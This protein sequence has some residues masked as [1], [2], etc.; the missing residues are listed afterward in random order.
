MSWGACSGWAYP[1]DWP[2]RLAGGRRSD[3]ARRFLTAPSARRPNA[4]CKDSISDVLVIVL[5][6]NFLSSRVLLRRNV[7]YG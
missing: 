7:G 5:I 4:V 1:Q 3:R 6:G 2:R